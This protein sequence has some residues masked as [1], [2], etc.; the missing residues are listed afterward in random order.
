MNILSS[1]PSWLMEA[2]LRGSA[3]IILVWVLAPLARRWIG[4]RAAHL[5]WLMALVPLLVPA[6]PSSPLTFAGAPVVQQ[7]VTESRFAGAQIFVSVEDGPAERTAAVP[8]RTQPRTTSWLPLLL[9]VWGFGVVLV[10]AL[11]LVQG[12]R[13]K[14]LVRRA[15]EI[16]HEPAVVSVLAHLPNMPRSVCIRETGELRSPAVC[17]VW[18]PTILLPL[19]WWKQLTPAEFECVLL[20]ELGHIRRG[21]LVWRWAFLSARAVHWFNPLVW[22]A[23]RSARALKP[24]HAS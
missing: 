10:G 21:D 11:A 18:K 22:L 24:V 13:A 3:G 19:G 8:V 1:L 6:L 12:I 17:G 15:P 16:T 7:E 14:L 4:A 2:T 9:P 5:L 20:H 23:E